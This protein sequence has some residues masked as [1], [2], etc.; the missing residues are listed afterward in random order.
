VNPLRTT[1]CTT[2][3][4]IVYPLE[5]HVLGGS[6][7]S[8]IDRI[9]RMFLDGLAAARSDVEAEEVL[10]CYQI[11]SVLLFVK[12]VVPGTGLVGGRD[13]CWSESFYIPESVHLVW[14]ISAPSSH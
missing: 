10:Y 4:L 3:A 8:R 7:I 9:G 5:T 14:G 2:G 12:A 6:P 13:P 11:G 1:A